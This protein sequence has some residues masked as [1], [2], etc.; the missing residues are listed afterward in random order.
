MSESNM[1]EVKK[2]PP[3]AVI[4]CCIGCG[5][6]KTVCPTGAIQV[7]DVAEI[8]ANVCIGCGACAGRCPMAAIG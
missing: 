3:M 1:N 5:A 6:C 7:T 8:D 4:G 2:R